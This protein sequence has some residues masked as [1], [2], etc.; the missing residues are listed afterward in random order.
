M[1]SQEKQISQH[2]RSIQHCKVCGEHVQSTDKSTTRRSVLFSLHVLT[3]DFTRIT[4]CEHN[5]Y[6][7]STEICR[8]MALCR[9]VNCDSQEGKQ[10]CIAIASPT[11]TMIKT[12]I[13]ASLGLRMKFKTLFMSDEEKHAH[14]PSF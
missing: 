1:S 13:C 9:S 11:V 2:G 4:Y 7:C 12:R 5:G 14:R 6:I 8:V 10:S 3:K